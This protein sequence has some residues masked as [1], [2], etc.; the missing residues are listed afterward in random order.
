MKV[1]PNCEIETE[2]NH[3]LAITNGRDT[4]QFRLSSEDLLTKPPIKELK[5]PSEDV[6]FKLCTATALEKVLRV[7]KLMEHTRIAIEGDEPK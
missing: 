6:K 2:N 3:I 7:S 5:L 4:I 1:I